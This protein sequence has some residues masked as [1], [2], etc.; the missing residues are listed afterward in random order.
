MNE[1]TP[2]RISIWL[3]LAAATLVFNAILEFGVSPANDLGGTYALVASFLIGIVVSGFGVI[4]C[5]P[6]IVLS[7]KNPRYLAV[8]IV[9]L[10]GNAVML[11]KTLNYI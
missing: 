11:C 4:L 7:H 1:P 5:A 10:V 6:A 9:L 2:K 3:S 8:S